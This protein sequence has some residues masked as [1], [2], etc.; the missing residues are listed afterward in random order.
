MEYTHNLKI[1]LIDNDKIIEDKVILDEIKNLLSKNNTHMIEW[2]G[3]LQNFTIKW[4]KIILNEIN[5]NL[6]GD[7]F[8]CPIYDLDSIIL[9]HTQKTFSKINCKYVVKFYI[10]RLI[11][12]KKIDKNSFGFV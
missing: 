1:I 8:A 6:M 3:K 11:Y 10:S 7:L 4:D 2:N 12:D 9:H 5:Q